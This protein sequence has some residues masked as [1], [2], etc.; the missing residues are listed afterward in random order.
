MVKKYTK[1]KEEKTGY[2]IYK[3]QLKIGDKKC[4]LLIK[5]PKIIDDS[6]PTRSLIQDPL[7]AVFFIYRKDN[8]SCE[9]QI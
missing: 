7:A 2:D 4:E 3:K 9:E 8:W 6:V 5:D 1:Q